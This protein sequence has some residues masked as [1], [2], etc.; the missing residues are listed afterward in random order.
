MFFR[1]VTGVTQ[2]FE[3]RI[4]E[5]AMSVTIV[6]WGT[7]LLDPSNPWNSAAWAKMLF[8]MPETAWGTLCVCLGL[9]RLVALTINGTFADTAYSKFSPHVRGVTAVL[10][11]TVWFMVFLSVSSVPSS[12]SGIYQLPLGLDLWCV[13]H[14][15]REVGRARATRDGMVR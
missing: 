9:L 3:S 7:R 15:W 10:G 12:S 2:H 1:I 14:A 11:A 4:T 8:W 5:W 13:F 6:W